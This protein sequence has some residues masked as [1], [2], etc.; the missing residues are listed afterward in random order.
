MVT[1]KRYLFN[2]AAGV[3]A[4]GVNTGYGIYAEYEKDKLREEYRRWKTGGGK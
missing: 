3:L 4:I 1:I 2:P